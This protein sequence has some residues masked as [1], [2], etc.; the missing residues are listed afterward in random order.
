M[1]CPLSKSRFFFSFEHYTHRSPLF[2]KTDL[3]TLPMGPLYETG[4]LKHFINKFDLFSQLYPF[5]RFT[6]LDMTKVSKSFWRQNQ[7]L[8]LEFISHKIPIPISRQSDWK[9]LDTETISEYHGTRLRNLNHSILKIL[10]NNFPEFFWDSI[11]RFPSD[12]DRN[13]KR[14]FVDGLLLKHLEWV[15]GGEHLEAVTALTLAQVPS[16]NTILGLY[17][18]SPW[19]LFLEVYPELAER[20]GREVRLRVVM[21]GLMVRE[22]GVE[23]QEDLSRITSKLFRKLSRGSSI[24]LHH[25]NSLQ[26]ALHTAY[27]ELNPN[28]EKAPQGFWKNL[29]SNALLPRVMKSYC[30]TKQADWYRLS[31]EQMSVIYGKAVSKFKMIQ[32][33]EVWL[34]EE[35]WHVDRFSEK[36]NRKARQKYLGLKLLELFKGEV[37][38]EEYPLPSQQRMH[39]VDFYIPGLKLAIEYQGEQHYFNFTKWVG[40]EAQ[41]VRDAEKRIV[42]H[43]NGLK[44][45]HV[46]YW[47][48]NSIEK[49]KEM[50]VS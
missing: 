11:W 44:L 45:V 37:I 28:Y 13:G 8:Y 6:I 49:L 10:R 24:L 19:E 26:G 22:C 18:G 17:G 46:P 14:V 23:V 2:L 9:F 35:S 38:L 39:L 50:L 25:N 7:K 30:I 31:V 1:V 3:K 15:E 48:D 4:T 36:T 34:P 12:A 42:C 27:P 33:L 5:F 21:D 32:L 16:G 43:E 47:W 20:E 41:R 29:H 40:L